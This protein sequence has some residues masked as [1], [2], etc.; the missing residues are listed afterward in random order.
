MHHVLS[1]LSQIGHYPLRAEL[2]ESSPSPPEVTSSTDK[3][4]KRSA[5]LCNYLLQMYMYMYMYMYNSRI[6]K[7]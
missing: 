2:K 1:C 5:M 7:E 3:E 4:T 6:A